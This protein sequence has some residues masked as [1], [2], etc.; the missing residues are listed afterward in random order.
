MEP[1]LC[2][3]VIRS[4]DLARSR[5][6][7]E[8]LGLTFSEEQHGN[9]PR[10]LACQ[11]GQAVFEIYPLESA[12]QCTS[13][14]RLGFRVANVDRALAAALEAGGAM[15]APA[16]DGRWGRRAVVTDPDGHAVELLG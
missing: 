16:K 9:G 14:A 6:F 4:S 10:H 7:Y 15:K 1:A 5:R 2:L 8:A 3:L 13:A 11:F 12:E